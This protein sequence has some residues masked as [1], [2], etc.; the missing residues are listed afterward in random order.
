MRRVLAIFLGCLVTCCCKGGV[1]LHRV[2]AGIPD[3]SG[4]VTAESTYGKFSVKVPVPFNDYTVEDTN[5]SHLVRKVETVGCTNSV[6]IKFTA[7]RIFYRSSDT[8][9]NV[10]EKMKSGDG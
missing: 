9:A 4:W 3:K 5:S 2:Q 8:A 10:F 1:T 7:S 6:G